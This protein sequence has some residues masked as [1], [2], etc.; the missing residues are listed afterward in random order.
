MKIKLSACVLIATLCLQLTAVASAS[1]S[2]LMLEYHV[3]ELRAPDQFSVTYRTGV[4]G[5]SGGFALT[6][7]GGIA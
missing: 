2:T 1:A 4:K 6:Q 7:G 5:S 3:H